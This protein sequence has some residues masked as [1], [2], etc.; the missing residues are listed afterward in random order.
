ID[1]AKTVERESIRRMKCAHVLARIDGAEEEEAVSHNWRAGLSTCIVLTR[2]HCLHAAVC[3]LELR[4][5]AFQLIRAPVTEARTSQIVRSALGDD[6]HDAARR[7]TVLGFVSTSLDLDFLHKVVRR[8]ITERSEDDGIGAER[9]IA[10]V[11]HID[12][13]DHIL[14]VQ[15]ASTGNGW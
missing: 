1:I 9:S 14:I 7:L 5:R 3:R 10:G 12:A 13:V 15:T 11:R 2:A 6:V 4:P 8:R